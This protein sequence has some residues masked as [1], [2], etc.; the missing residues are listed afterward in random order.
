MSGNAHFARG[1]EPAEL[2]LF[3]GLFDL[4]LEFWYGPCLRSKILSVSGRPSVACQSK[5]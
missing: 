2:V 4:R 1:C 3:L 5:R